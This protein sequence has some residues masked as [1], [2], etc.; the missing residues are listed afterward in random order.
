M[1]E[2]VPYTPSP[3]AP[4]PLLQGVV[5]SA[6]PYGGDVQLAAERGPVVYVA[7]AYG[8][9][10]AVRRE[11]LPTL[12]A[13]LPLAPVAQG[14]DP[15]AQR[16]LAAGLGGG[17]LSAGVGFGLGQL[18]NAL[19]G[20]GSGV[21]LLAVLLAAARI[22]PPARGGGDVHVTQHITSRWWGRSTGTVR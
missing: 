10:V 20:V 12:P 9:F 13:P 3:Y 11:D 1:N 5:E 19:A 8:G 7:G 14:P 4:S 2:P 21:A 16:M 6:R 18:L 15:L 17:A 22:I